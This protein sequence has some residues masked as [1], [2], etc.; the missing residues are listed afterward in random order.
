M[1]RALMVG[2]YTETAKFSI[3]TFS[4]T[5][6]LVIETHLYNHILHGKL[7]VTSKYA[8][9]FMAYGCITRK[10]IVHVLL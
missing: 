5:Y 9:F 7:F 2:F 1:F 10:S 4:F 3:Q 6:G 8:M